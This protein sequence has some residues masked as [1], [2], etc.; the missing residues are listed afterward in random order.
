MMTILKKEKKVTKKL[1]N[2]TFEKTNYMEVLGANRVIYRVTCSIKI[3][4]DKEYVTYGVEA[5]VKMGPVRLNEKIDDFS[6]DLQQAVGFV[7]LLVKNNIKPT[8]IYNAALCYL[9]KTI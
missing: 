1:Q 3:D 7:E 8:L 6:C 5:E 2:S 4:Y 9:K